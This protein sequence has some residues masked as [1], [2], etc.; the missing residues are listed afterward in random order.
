MKIYALSENSMKNLAREKNG[1][2]RKRKRKFVSEQMRVLI[3]I[4]AS[5]STGIDRS[6]SSLRGPFVCLPPVN[7]T[8]I[9]LG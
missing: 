8:A 9:Y 3:L 5:K 4:V 7:Q 6:I 1:T 2:R